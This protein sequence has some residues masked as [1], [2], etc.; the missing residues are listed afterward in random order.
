MPPS[1]DMNAR[2]T[3]EKIRFVSLVFTGPAVYIGKLAGLALYHRIF[4]IYQGVRWQIYGIAFI[5][6]VLPIMSLWYAAACHPPRDKGWTSFNPK[7]QGVFVFGI[8]VGAATLLVD[9]LIAI[10]PWPIIIRLKLPL[11]KRI[12]VG[13]VLLVGTVALVADAV[14]MYYR[15]ALLQNRDR[16]SSGYKILL[17]SF[18]DVAISVICSSMP[19]A[20]QCFRLTLGQTVCFLNFRSI[21]SRNLW[22]RQGEDVTDQHY[23]SR[24]ASVPPKRRG[25]Y[26]LDMSITALSTAHLRVSEDVELSSNQSV[27]SQHPTK[28]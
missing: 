25:P 21:V 6:L 14:V 15:V 3:Y 2:D 28:A 19:A 27:R 23:N 11:K 26:S 12:G 10:L 16:Y 18:V 20:A 5:G 22:G 1:E 4:G 24:K 13:V 8:T 7:C 17:C 9:V